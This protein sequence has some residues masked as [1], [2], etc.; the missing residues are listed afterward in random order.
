[1]GDFTI[2]GC[3]N[4]NST[5]YNPEAT[6]DD[7]SCINWREIRFQSF[8]GNS[9]IGDVFNNNTI[10]GLIEN[11]ILKDAVLFSE[12]PGPLFGQWFG[13]LTEL[14]LNTTYCLKTLN[15]AVFSYT[16]LYTE[17]IVGLECDLQ[18]GCTDSAALNYNPGA[19]QDSGACV[20]NVFGCTDSEALNYNLNATADD[21]TCE[22]ETKTKVNI[23]KEYIADKIS[24]LLISGTGIDADN[25]S[26]NYEIDLKAS[27]KTIK[28]GKVQSGV[29]NTDTLVLYKKDIDASSEDMNIITM[30]T[31][32]FIDIETGEPFSGWTSLNDIKDHINVHFAV[33]KLDYSYYIIT[34]LQA[35]DGGESRG[36]FIG[37][38]GVFDDSIVNPLNVSQFLQV[39]KT[40]TVID[41]FK[42]RNILDI[43]IH[44]LTSNQ[45]TRKQ[46]II[47]LFAEI[48]A[49]KGD[50]PDYTFDSNDDS[51]NDTWESDIQENQ[52]EFSD[53]SD[54]VANELDGNITRLDR[55]ADGTDQSGL[56]LES[57]RSTLDGHLTDIGDSIVN[58][59]DS[60]PEYVN[61]TD[62]YLKI[63]DL[64]Q[65]VIVR[66]RD[67]DINKFE[68]EVCNTDGLVGPSYLVNGFTFTTWIR[69]K[70]KT[71]RGTILNFGNPLRDLNP[72]GFMLETY[73]VNKDDLLLN[74]EDGTCRDESELELPIDDLFQNKNNERFIRLVVRDID[75]NL[76]DSH[77]GLP[78]MPRLTTAGSLP[79]LEQNPDY[80]FNYTRIPVDL[81]EWYYVVATFNPFG[82]I[83][84]GNL[85]EGYETSPEFWMGHIDE[86]GNVVA[87]SGYG[88]KCKVE[89]IS[90][91]NLLIARG[92]KI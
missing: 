10:P 19:T 59:D 71:G 12:Y 36:V 61:K 21:N 55:H 77:F 29:E 69:F 33:R 2:L 66:N 49:L 64:N 43:N 65:F 91:T 90:R 17:E 32:G 58:I 46:R 3:T 40:K 11:S 6:N 45:I 79:A 20:Y 83:E 68:E 14:E 22:Y 84:G 24:E 56:T 88:S 44:E 74:V 52:D 16:G 54:V 23:I 41:P 53:D 72:K 70:D 28:G 47:N 4:E 5:N 39:D 30:I 15:D 50:I 48:S 34:G 8:I 42:A 78:D 75:G 13:T 18:I 73:T 27:Q 92:Y 26:I 7:G 51:I 60:R 80:M 89:F 1:M 9:G 67:I 38:D 76:L 86:N 57:L 81:S 63:R 37:Q 35:I 87:N 85:F 25:N 82:V 62:G 31:E